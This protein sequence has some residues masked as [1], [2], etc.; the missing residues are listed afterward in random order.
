[1][2]ASASMWKTCSRMW[3]SNSQLSGPTG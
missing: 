3:S 2:A 1:M